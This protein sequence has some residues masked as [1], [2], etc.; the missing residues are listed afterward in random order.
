MCIFSRMMYKK[1]L[2]MGLSWGDELSRRELRREKVF[3]YIISF[4]SC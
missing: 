2:I 1:L 3:F 4:W